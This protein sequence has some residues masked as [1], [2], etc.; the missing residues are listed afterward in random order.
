M[1]GGDNKGKVKKK[2][3]LGLFHKE[4]KGGH[5]DA[6]RLEEGDSRS[7]GKPWGL[8]RLRNG[9]LAVMMK[10]EGEDYCMG[11]TSLVHEGPDTKQIKR[12]LHADGSA[13]GF[14]FDKVHHMSTLSVFDSSQ[15]ISVVFAGTDVLSY[16]CWCDGLAT[17]KLVPML[18]CPGSDDCSWCCSITCS[19]SMTE[20]NRLGGIFV[21]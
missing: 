7:A 14:F 19:S 20:Q 9:R 16:Y 11:T 5:G 18:S 4:E 8:D 3:F 2:A 15:V 10:S 6:N 21:L 13:S 17:S 12:K 1:V